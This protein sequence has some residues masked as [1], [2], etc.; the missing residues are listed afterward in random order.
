MESPAVSKPPESPGWTADPRLGEL[1][2]KARESS[3]AEALESIAAVLAYT[4][5][6]IM[7]DTEW[8]LHRLTRWA[9]A[10]NP[11]TPAHILADLATDEHRKVRAAVADNPSTPIETLDTLVKD[12]SAAVWLNAAANRSRKRCANDSAVTSERLAG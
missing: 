6:Q 8:T 7:F 11:K 9:L 3:D 4:A 12:S 5:T 2:S 1:F 10:Y